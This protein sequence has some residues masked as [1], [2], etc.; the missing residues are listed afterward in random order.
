[1]T[2]VT[3]SRRFLLLALLPMAMASG[4]VLSVRG[5]QAEP[6]RTHTVAPFRTTHPSATGM[7]APGCPDAEW[8]SAAVDF[9]WGNVWAYGF[10]DYRVDGEWLQSTFRFEQ[11]AGRAAFRM[12][13][14]LIARFGGVM[15]SSIE[16]FHERTDRGN[17]FREQAVRNDVLVFLGNGED[18]FRLDDSSL[19]MGDITLAA[20]WTLLTTDGFVPGLS[21]E[22]LA[23]L[24]SGNQNEL[25][26]MGEPVF[27]GGFMA[28]EGFG[29]APIGLYLGLLYLT[30][31]A[32]TLAGQPIKQHYLSGVAGAECSFGSH[33]SC[34]LQY[35][36]QT[37]VMQDLRELS[38]PMHELSLGIRRRWKGGSSFDIAIIENSGRF[39]NSTDLGFHAGWSTVF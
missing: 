10:S 39:G 20:A 27:G 13:F 36:G 6:L 11:R 15:D 12:E 16:G 4:G 33:W 9:T 7:M 1:M 22:I 18:T 23:T 5:G 38:D 29:D 30:T 3:G 25:A 32:K 35:L 28:T 2:P 8:A 34:V 31:P 26:G 24:P 37:P 17:Q 21:A 14:P 19:D